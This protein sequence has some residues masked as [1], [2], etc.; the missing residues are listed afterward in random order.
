MPHSDSDPQ[1]DAQL[2]GAPAPEGLRERLRRIAEE[3]RDA[4]T[5]DA[6]DEELNAPLVPADLLSRLKVVGEEELL[7][8][9]IRAVADPSWGFLARLRVIANQRPRRKFARLAVAAALMLI[10]G[11][12][13]LLGVLGLASLAG[14]PAPSELAQTTVLHRGPLEIATDLA[15]GS[16]FTHLSQPNFDKPI[17]VFDDSFAEA[18]F[19]SFI[20]M[21]APELGPA[22]DLF[23]E[24]EGGFEPA[25]DLLAARH[26]L[27]TSPYSGDDTPPELSVAPRP[28]SRGVTPPLVPGFDRP[29]LLRHWTHPIVAPALN[30]ALYQSPAP[31]SV[32]TD[33][34]EEA[35]RM[36]TKR[37]PDPRRVHVEDFIAAT[38][39]PFA[40]PKPG[41]VAPQIAA[42]PNRFR[43]GAYTLQVGV[44]AGPVGKRALAATH[45]MVAID[46][47]EA[48]QAAAR[49]QMIRTAVLA[50]LDHL[51]P[52]DRV[53][54][55]TVEQPPRVLIEG[56]SLSD[57]AEMIAAL[58]SL[59]AAPETNLGAGLQQALLTAQNNDED[60]PLARRAVLVT[61][62]RSRV[63]HSVEEKLLDLLRLAADAGCTTQVV[64]LAGRPSE[65]LT[66]IAA[67][68]SGP[69][70]ESHNAKS[71]RYA[72]V[73][74]LTG[75]GSLVGPDVVATVKFNPDRVLAYR[76]IGHES[77]ALGGLMPTEVS[78]DLRSREAVSTLFDDWLK[79]EGYGPIAVVQVQ[80][81]DAQTGEPRT[82]EK[83]LKIDDLPTA[84][85]QAPGSL[86][87]AV[88][89]AQL[90]E[91]LR[92]SPFA[93]ERDLFRVI[94][95]LRE[96]ESHLRFSSNY[97]R[98]V[99]LAS[100]V[101]RLRRGR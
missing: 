99:A 28:L 100:Q 43:Q 41:G 14:R 3:P 54:L 53:S 75:V 97:R 6:I 98:L 13:H 85:D 23:A 42:A 49:M 81:R 67:A 15:A 69:L 26:G 25:T 71:L 4:W 30:R 62:G 78:V 34:F 74:T 12:F 68:G 55:L 95:A 36:A 77:I 11:S 52:R 80:W 59:V 46:V 50:M 40:M 29:F 35:E 24:L 73:E 57:A 66:R 65:L 38:Q 86:Q 33:S 8:R 87:Q 5:D 101:S 2:R 63:D 70:Y 91:I 92:D 19:V 47:S 58:D 89:A 16:T 45:L 90:A 7:D 93:S 27:L 39:I 64:H 48:T 72:L 31:L 10:V 82:A 1:L 37:L 96:S 51:G 84:F 83:T 17:H 94:T 44:Q 56:A 18:T 60:F 88:I 61:D 32:K 21:D 20:D 76:M 79:G 22:G 9:R